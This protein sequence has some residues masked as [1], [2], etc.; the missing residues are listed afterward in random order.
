MT[1]YNYG[2]IYKIVPIKGDEGDVYIGST[3]KRWLSN[4]MSTHRYSYQRWKEGKYNKTMSFDLFEKYGLENCVICLIENLNCTTKDQLLARELFYVQSM[5]C[6][7][8]N[9]PSRSKAQ[10]RIDNRDTMIVNS[11]EYYKNNKE[12]MIKK[13]QLPFI[14]VCGTVTSVGHKA[15]HFRTK[16]HISYVTVNNIDKE[17]GKLN[18]NV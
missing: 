8:K 18:L 4:R 3:T 5:A 13:Q 9:S 6:I 1:N 17:V 15:V 2:K 7:N 16:K 11:R 10:Y 12:A 14:C